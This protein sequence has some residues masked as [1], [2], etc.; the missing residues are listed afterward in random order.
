VAFSPY[1]AICKAASQSSRPELSPAMWTTLA[2]LAARKCPH[3]QQP[4]RAINEI[5]DMTSTPGDRHDFGGHS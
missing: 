3:G 2:T 4:L 1:G 5:E